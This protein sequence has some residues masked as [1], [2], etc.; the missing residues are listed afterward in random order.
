LPK[1]EIAFG[2]K[3]KKPVEYA[4]TLLCARGTGLFMALEDL[5]KVIPVSKT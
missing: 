2:V 3:S 5:A 4:V 1:G